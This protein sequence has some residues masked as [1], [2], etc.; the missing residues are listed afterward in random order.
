MESAGLFA[1]AAAAGV[2]ALAMFTVSDHLIT[3]E[4]TTPEQ[5]QTAFTRMIEIA[6]ELA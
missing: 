4:E 3:H 6:L 2:D 1:N 5:R